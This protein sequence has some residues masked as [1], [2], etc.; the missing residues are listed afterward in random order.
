MEINIQVIED[1][2]IVIKGLRSAAESRKISDNRK[3]ALK[4]RLHEE[5]FIEK[6]L[7]CITFAIDYE[8]NAGRRAAAVTGYGNACS[9][10]RGSD[11]RTLDVMEEILKTEI[12][13]I[14]EKQGYGCSIARHVFSKGEYFDIIIKW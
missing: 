8:A 14:L 6:V 3:A 4:D 11:Y 2:A 7:D 10:L 5:H 1:N 12:V 9:P 13:P